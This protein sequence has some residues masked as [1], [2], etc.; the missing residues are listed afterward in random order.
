M[1]FAGCL[2]SS[3]VSCALLVVGGPS[4]L[5][6]RYEMGGVHLTKTDCWPRY[7][8]SRT[9]TKWWLWRHWSELL[10]YE[11]VQRML[12]LQNS[13]AR[14]ALQG[15]QQD[16]EWSLDTERRWRQMLWML[17]TSRNQQNAGIWAKKAVGSRIAKEIWSYKGSGVQIL[18]PI[19][20]WG[21]DLEQVIPR[22]ANRGKIKV[23]ES[24]RV[25][26]MPQMRRLRKPRHP[27]MQKMQIKSSCIQK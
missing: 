18:L 4:M 8:Q 7:L 10:S 26:R 21:Y 14:H 19:L 11:E 22:R 27:N 25:F 5:S 24:D 1:L 16:C 23:E 2:W 9:G 15:L 13:E 6:S 12:S 3:F 17:R 20:L